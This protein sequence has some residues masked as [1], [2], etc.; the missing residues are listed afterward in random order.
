LSSPAR[1]QP[2]G[3]IDEPVLPCDDYDV[4]V[5]SDLEEDDA[6]IE[7]DVEIEDDEDP[8]IEVQSDVDDSQPAARHDA[9]ALDGVSPEREPEP[10][11][12]YD[13]EVESELI[14]GEEPDLEVTCSIEQDMNSS[15]TET[16]DA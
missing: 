14:D 13:V 1:P 2:R 11:P 4:E 6:D 15:E 9:S 8:D 12:D 5:V 10:E 7:V 16:S 3:K